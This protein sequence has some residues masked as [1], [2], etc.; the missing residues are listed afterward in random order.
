MRIEVLNTGTELLLGTTL[1]THGAWIGQ[2]LFPLGL[3]LQRQTTVPDGEEIRDAISEA[4]S[5]SDALIVTGGLGPTSD[6]IT[7]ELTAEILNLELMEDEHAIRTMEAFFKERGKEMVSDNRKQALIPVGA[8]VLPNPNGTAPG[9]YIPPRLSK[10]TACAVFLLPGPPRELRP[11]FHAEVVSRLRALGDVDESR[12]NIELKFTGIGE[13]DF[14]NGVDRELASIKGL[15]YGY[16]ARPSELDLRLIGRDEIIQ[17]ARD[18]VVTPFEKHLISEDGSTLPEV[19]VR[20]L[21]EKGLKL[22]VAESCTGGLIASRITDIPGASLVLTH[23]FITYA[24]DA[25]IQMLGVKEESLAK[26]GAVSEEVAREMAEGTLR[27]SGADVAVAVTGIAGPTGGTDEKPVGTVFLSLASK[28]GKTMCFQ[29]LYVRD[30]QAFK[31]SVSQGALNMV[32]R[33][34]LK[35]S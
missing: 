3:R 35:R 17:K 4:I 20:G 14:H 15:E 22:A 30:R 2:A 18:L 21:T 32:R 13:S 33:W 6:D 12:K 11:M 10:D 5:R 16:C 7:R 34:S 26:Y 31:F 28:G 9:V 27:A 23:G 25:K 24:N 19:L 1:N 8:D 29:Q